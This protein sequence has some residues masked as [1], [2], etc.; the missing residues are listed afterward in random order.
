MKLFLVGFMGCGKTTLGKHLASKLKYDFIDFDVLFETR[1]RI[2]ITDFFLKYG[3]SHFRKIESQ[4]LKEAEFYDRTV[5]STGGGTACFFDNMEW[6][7]RE[8]IT[9]Y[10]KM[11]AETLHSR[12]VK[13]KLKRPLIADLTNDELKIYIE[14]QLKQREAFYTMASLTVDGFNPKIDEIAGSVMAK[15]LSNS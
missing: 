6:M 3:E 15:M 13:S 7:N 14:N 8:G 1:F 10:V 2:S 11:S 12:L 4:M 9:I 5:F